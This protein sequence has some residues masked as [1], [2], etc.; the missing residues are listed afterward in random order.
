MAWCCP[1]A[2]ELLMCHIHTNFPRINQNTQDKENPDN[3]EYKSRRPIIKN[4]C[5]LGITISKR[6]SQEYRITIENSEYWLLN[7]NPT[8]DET[9]RYLNPARLVEWIIDKE[10]GDS[11][12]TV[13]KLCSADPWKHVG[14]KRSEER[15]RVL[16]TEGTS[17][18]QR[19]PRWSY[20]V[21]QLRC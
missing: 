19:K 3:T 20:R 5:I 7:N 17:H 12:D 6:H 4:F 16:S 11:S 9:C 15:A 18:G 13:M 10:H 14:Q 21:A 1:S 8:A 2:V